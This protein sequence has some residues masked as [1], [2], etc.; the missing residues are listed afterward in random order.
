MGFGVGSFFFR[1]MASDERNA[2]LEARSPS[3]A[4]I[5]CHSL[6]SLG[7]R[8]KACLRSLPFKILFIR[9]Y[10]DF[11]SLHVHWCLLL[12]SRCMFSLPRLERNLWRGTRVGMRVLH[13]CL[14]SYYRCT[15]GLVSHCALP[16]RSGCGIILLG[17]PIQKL[18]EFFWGARL[19]CPLC[20]A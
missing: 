3:L 8:W 9:V 14:P 6:S 10:A 18:D 2:V 1:A 5:F 17:G 19:F 4:E 16:Q 7:L 20:R 15:R 12:H 11:F 13:T